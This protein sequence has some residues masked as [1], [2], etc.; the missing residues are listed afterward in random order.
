MKSKFLISVFALSV[1]LIIL[2]RI[3]KII[4]DGVDYS[5]LNGFLEIVYKK[6]TGIAFSIPVPIWVSVVITIALVV[7]GMIFVLKNF[8]LDK[9]ISIIVVSLILAGGLGNM[10]D[11]VFLGYVVDYISIWQ[12]PVFNFADMCIFFGAMTIALKFDKMLL[13]GKKHK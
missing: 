12:W 8:D 10:Y 6:N 4:A 2:D 7:F 13:S 5:F 1:P 11:R 9:K 3:L